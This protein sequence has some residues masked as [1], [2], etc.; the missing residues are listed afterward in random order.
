LSGIFFRC[1]RTNHSNGE[2]IMSTLPPSGDLRFS[3]PVIAHRNAVGG[4]CDIRQF[5][6]NRLR[7]RNEPA[8]ASGSLCDDRPHVR[9]ASAHAGMSAV[10]LLFETPKDG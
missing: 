1:S 5:R 6:H 7:Q 3:S 10:T 4:H 2:E 9:A 8:G